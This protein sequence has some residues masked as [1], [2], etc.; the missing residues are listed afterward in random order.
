MMRGRGFRHAVQA[1]AQG[2]AELRGG[3]HQRLGVLSPGGVGPY[4]GKHLL[5]DIPAKGHAGQFS[6]TAQGIILAGSGF[7]PGC[8]GLKLSQSLIY[9]VCNALFHGAPV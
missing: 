4:V 8:P 2:V 9:L 5:A 6:Q 3:V 1:V 7:G